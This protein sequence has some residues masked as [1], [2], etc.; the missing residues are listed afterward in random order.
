[1]INILSLC[2]FLTSFKPK[3]VQALEEIEFCKGKVAHYKVSRYVR[4]G[5]DFPMTVTGKIQ[6][7]KMRKISIK[8][9]G[10]EEQETA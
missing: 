5:D 10:L 8:E 2:I 1:M 4:F 3:L 9:L 6:K 7:Y